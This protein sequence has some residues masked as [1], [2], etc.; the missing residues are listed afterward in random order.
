MLADGYANYSVIVEYNGIAWT[1]P[2]CNDDEVS[3]VLFDPYRV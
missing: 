1:G 3:G 2:R